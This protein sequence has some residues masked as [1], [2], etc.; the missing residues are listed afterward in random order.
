M[1][2]MFW[3]YI[4]KIYFCGFLTCHSMLVCESIK[5]GIRTIYAQDAQLDFIDPSNQNCDLNHFRRILKFLSP[6][7]GYESLIT[8]KGVDY[9]NKN[10]FFLN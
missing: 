2:I 5:N 10:I 7:I 4:Q 6:E 3:L 1:N 8:Q 9:F